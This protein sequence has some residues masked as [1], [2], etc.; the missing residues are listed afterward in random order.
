MCGPV[1]GPR[2]VVILSVTL[3][4]TLD[5]AWLGTV[6]PNYVQSGCFSVFTYV[7]S[8]WL[9]RISSQIELFFSEAGGEGVSISGFAACF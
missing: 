9:N 2:W 1:C 5:A 3:N 7:P 4:A 6:W 8:D